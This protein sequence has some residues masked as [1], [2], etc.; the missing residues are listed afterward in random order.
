MSKN[1]LAVNETDPG[2]TILLLDDDPLHL[3]ELSEVLNANGYETICCETVD[4]AV[5]ALEK[6]PSFAIVDLFLKGDDGEELSNHFV[7]AYLIPKGIAYGRMSSAPHLVP[8]HLIG[9]WVVDK[10]KFQR[11]PEMV[12]EYLTTL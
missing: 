3:E 1:S 9:K 6:C 12:L 8:D 11:D 10:R 4:A 5:A 7:T 2:K